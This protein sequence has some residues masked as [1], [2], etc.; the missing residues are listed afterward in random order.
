MGAVYVEQGINVVEE[1]FKKAMFPTQTP[2]PGSPLSHGSPSSS[3]YSGSFFSPPPPQPM[4]APPPVPPDGI[5]PSLAFVNQTA[6]QKGMN[7][8]YSESSSGP[9]HNPVWEVRCSRKFLSLLCVILSSFLQSMGTKV[10]SEQVELGKLPKKKRLAG[11][12]IVRD[13]LVFNRV[14]LKVYS[15]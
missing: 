9:P 6:L 7:I 5:Q 3:S 4:A 8:S 15:D 12:S 1:W 2:P 10:E 13:G 11:H 14:T